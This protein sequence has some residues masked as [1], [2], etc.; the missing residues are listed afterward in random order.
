[1]TTP[2]NAPAPYVRPNLNRP[3]VQQMVSG[4]K[5]IERDAYGRYLM[6]LKHFHFEPGKKNNPY[7]QADV[8]IVEAHDTRTF[9]PDPKPIAV[10]TLYPAGK[11]TALCMP[12]GRAGTATN[13]AR[14]DYDDAYLTAFINAV[15][16]VQRGQAFDSEK[17]LDDLLAQGKIDHDSVL[18]WF[19]RRPETKMRKIKDPRDPSGKTVLQE[20]EQTFCKD[21]FD[22]VTIAPA[23]G[24]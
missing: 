19:D 22:A 2:A 12:T 6:A 20:L 15:C 14:P 21:F 4:V 10:S 11:I 7:Y 8:L 24:G 23:V 13:P 1:M 3:K 16:R 5:F 18:F 9:E 17:A